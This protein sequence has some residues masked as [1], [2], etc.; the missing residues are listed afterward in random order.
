MFPSPNYTDDKF[1]I[2]NNTERYCWAAYLLFVLLSSFV[3]DTLIL[4]A[5]FQRDAFKI[6]KL[7]IT[8]IRHIAIADIVTSISAVL[9]ALT[10][11]LVN[12]WILGDRLCHVTVY[13]RY[14]SYQSGTYLIAAL[15]TCKFLILRYPLKA[16]GWSTKRAHLVCSLIWASSMAIAFVNI[17]FT[18][19]DVLFD[20]RTYICEHGFNPEN[21]ITI[22]SLA[23][24]IY[25]FAPN[26]IIVLV[27]IPT[28]QY[29]AA[30]RRSARRARGNVPWQG[31]LTVALTAAIYCIS[32]VPITVYHFAK[33]WLRNDSSGWF[34]VKFYRV[35][36]FFLLINI[37]ANVYIYSL[38]IKSFRR[39]LVLKAVTICS[40]CRK[41]LRKSNMPPTAS[42]AGT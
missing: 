7:I 18:K 28:L 39:F 13:T 5:S 15:T 17:T 32:I 3:G 16:S 23:S 6:N 33:R 36:S 9:P 22:P 20:Y 10:S 30:A 1:G 14:I 38:T 41:T 11:L 19:D 34:Y 4:F 37:M 42:E 27:T 2:H 26:L 40:V 29:L 8:V 35:S 24:A 25:S 12:S 31:A 21:W